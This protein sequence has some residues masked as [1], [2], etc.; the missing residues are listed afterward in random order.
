M[1]T[2]MQIFQ[3]K[4]VR[5]LTVLAVLL[6]IVLF[7]YGWLA[8]N[9]WVMRWIEDAFFETELSHW[10]GHVVMYGAL[11]TAVLIVFPHLLNQPRRYFGLIFAIGL[12]QETLQ[13]ITFKHHFFTTNELFDL[14]VDL[15]AAG[16][17]FVVAK[18]I[19]RKRQ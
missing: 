14:M 3:N 16:I 10:V 5:L 19:S 2:T 15:I 6:G 7:P 11:T 18:I 17:V 12:V 4:N 13:L 8:N 1:I 9:W